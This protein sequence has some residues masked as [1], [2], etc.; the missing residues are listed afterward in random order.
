MGRCLGGFLVKN[1]LQ[2]ELRKLEILLGR[3]LTREEKALFQYAF[4]RG[5]IEA[6]YE[7]EQS[8]FIKGLGGGFLN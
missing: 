4:E 2:E 3:N 7:I 8:L 5:Y 1:K 6:I